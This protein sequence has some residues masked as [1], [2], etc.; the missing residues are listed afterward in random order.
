MITVTKYRKVP[1]HLRK[2][3]T[4]TR[5]EEEA[6]TDREVERG[7]EDMVCT[8]KDLLQLLLQVSSTQK[9]KFNILEKGI[10]KLNQN[11]SILQK[12]QIVQNKHIQKTQS[13]QDKHIEK[14]QIMQ[15]QEIEKM[16]TLQN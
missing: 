14:M 11:M 9:E 5:L 7:T 15:N 13:L 4:N 12:A 2:P 3:S 6:E 10:L 1:S 16:H 8:N